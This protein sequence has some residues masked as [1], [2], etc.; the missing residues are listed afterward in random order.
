MARWSI[1]EIASILKLVRDYE[2]VD[3]VRQEEIRLYFRKLLAEPGRS[4]P[5]E[6]SRRLE[7][8]LYRADEQHASTTAPKRDIPGPMVTEV[9][10][11]PPQ[12]LTEELE[13]TKKQKEQAQSPA[14]VK[15]VRR[16]VVV[17]PPE[18]GQTTSTVQVPPPPQPL[19]A[20]TKGSQTPV[21]LRFALQVVVG[22]FAF[23]IVALAAAALS[24]L[25]HRVEAW[26]V[27]PYI[28]LGLRG[29][30]LLTFAADI[31]VV[32]IFVVVEALSL[33][34]LVVADGWKAMRSKRGN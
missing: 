23:G 19:S 32:T 28:I 20:D 25:E 13:K 3:A 31:L 1:D 12:Q 33:I 5:P 15:R 8:L 7:A 27:S 22:I 14:Q 10:S 18:Q 4:L 6:I 21:V 17:P 34:R 24:L 2:R 29:V 16:Y 11:A 9:P 30:E 26:G